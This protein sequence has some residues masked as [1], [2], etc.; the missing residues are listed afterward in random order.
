MESMLQKKLEA[1]FSPCIVKISDLSSLHRG[2][3]GVSGGGKTHFK[4]VIVSEHFVKK[5]S[6]DRHRWIHE[7]LAEEL[8][9][10]H[11]LS[12]ILRAPGES[13]SAEYP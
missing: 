10:I 12:L 2:H 6:I 13:L 3:K 1:A 8:K 9:D 5:R 4:I 7:V 11:A